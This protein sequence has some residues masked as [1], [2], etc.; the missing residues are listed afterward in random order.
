MKRVCDL[1]HLASKRCYSLASKYW[2]YVNRLG[3]S[4]FKNTR[5]CGQC[6]QWTF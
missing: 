3:G 2:D 6:N 1:Y 5:K 4:A